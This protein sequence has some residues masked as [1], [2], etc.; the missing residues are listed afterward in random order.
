D[1]VYR[2]FCYND[3]AGQVSSVTFL[4]SGAPVAESV[5]GQIAEQEVWVRTPAVGRKIPALYLR[6]ERRTPF[7]RIPPAGRSGSTLYG[8]LYSVRSRPEHGGTIGPPPPFLAVV[9]PLYTVGGSG[10][11]PSEWCVGW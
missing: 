1:S 11:W 3:E 2:H 7:S 5:P 10:L 8:C 9:V 4:K 6:H